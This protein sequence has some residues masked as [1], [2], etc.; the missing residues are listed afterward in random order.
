[1]IAGTDV[2]CPRYNIDKCSGYAL[3]LE[4]RERM[5]KMPTSFRLTDEARYL[6]D[7]LEQRTALKV[8]AILELALRRLARDEGVERPTAQQLEQW[9]HTQATQRAS[10]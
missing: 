6:L 8:S 5:P 7:A 9:R 1:M 2:A 4:G 10:K 3:H